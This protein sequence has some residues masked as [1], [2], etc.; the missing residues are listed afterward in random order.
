MMFAAADWDNTFLPAVRAWLSGG[1]PLAYIY[2]PPWVLVPLVPFAVLPYEIG[3]VALFICAFLT[4]ALAA[5]KL[6]ARP[7]GLLALIASP[8]VL[9]ALVFGN[10]EWLTVLGFLLPAWAGI[11]FLLIKP[12][13]GVGVVIFI[14]ID[15]W[16]ISGYRGVVKTLIPVAIL[17]LLSFALFGNW[18]ARM[19]SY[20]QH[21]D[22]FLNLSFYP[23]TFPIG[24]ALMVAAIRSRRIEF[25]L[26][27]SPCFF[28]VLTP[29][30]WAVALLAIVGATWE[31][32]AAS[33][34]LWVLVLMARQ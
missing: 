8:L 14:L 19:A 5:R 15:R 31:I 2:N 13:I 9:D 27:A 25:A 24:F 30:C 22:S 29:Q 21:R 34:G 17:T 7:I 1:D 26:A 4:F 33:V 20:T 11:P 28:P 12:Q 23:Y 16:R 3:R 32:G 6:N 18:L 10:V